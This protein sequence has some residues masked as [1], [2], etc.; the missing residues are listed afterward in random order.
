[1][2]AYVSVSVCLSVCL[3]LSLSL[4]K[5]LNLLLEDQNVKLSSTS[6]ASRLPVCSLLSA[7]TPGHMCE[8]MSQVCGV[9]GG[10]QRVSDSL[11]LEL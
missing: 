1:M 6:P 9:Q 10:Q 3:S 11:E 2:L 5:S 7:R 8:Y 4:C